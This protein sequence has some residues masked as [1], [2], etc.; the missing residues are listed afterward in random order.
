MPP[1]APIRKEEIALELGVS[2]ALVSDAIGRLAE[3]ALVEVYPQHGSF[4]A[5]IRAEAVLESMFIRTALEIEAARRVTQYA[6]QDVH[7]RLQKN[8]DSQF[9]A[10]EKNDLA[11]FYD[12]DEEM[13][14]II[15]GALNSQRAER[16]LNA[17]RAPLDRP[18]RL[19]LPEIGR[20][21]STLQEHRCLVD[22]I[23]SGDPE[24]AAAAMRAHMNMV[25]KAV[26]REL[27]EIDAPQE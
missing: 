24:F 5:P 11:V 1:G 3:E 21:H 17:A 7:D 13:H 12:L 19:A 8:L 4:V 2:R 27:D 15:F 25:A 20:A 6:D 18:R 16:L 9:E 26:E 22:A 23:K 14:A 10:L